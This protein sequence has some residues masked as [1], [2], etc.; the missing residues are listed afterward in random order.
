MFVDSEVLTGPSGMAVYKDTIRKWDPP[1]GNVPVTDSDRDRI[2]NN[3][4][5]AFRSQ[6]FEI[7]VI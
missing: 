4:R 6:G 5:D 7:D 2:L 3:I 1:Y